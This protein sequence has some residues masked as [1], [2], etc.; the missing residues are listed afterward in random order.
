VG[1]A[2]QNEDAVPREVLVADIGG[3]NARFALADLATLELSHV[4][5]IRCAAQLSLT[6][7]LSAYLSDLPI[8]PVRA[9]IAVAA[10][11]LGEEVQL[12]NSTWSFTKNELRRTAGLEELL[13]INDFEALAHSLPHLGPG[14]L[15]KIGG[16][17]PEPWAPKI[18]LGP[19]TGLGIC[20]SHLVREGMD[21]S[22][23][24]GR[25]LLARRP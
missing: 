6:S 14:E 15:R 5:Q 9:A 13:V 7:A 24:R 19:G 23:G 25:A 3:T 20:P 22:G 2:V 10:P 8:S 16:S 1:K 11:V 12:T 21:R 4:G 18:V 17:A